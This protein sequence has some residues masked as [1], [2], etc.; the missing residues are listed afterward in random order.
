MLIEKAVKKLRAC[1]RV[2]C[3]LVCACVRCMYVYACECVG[4]RKYKRIQSQRFSNL[5]S[6]EE[7]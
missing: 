7:E 3:V 4:R 1:V 2:L 5:E 6:L